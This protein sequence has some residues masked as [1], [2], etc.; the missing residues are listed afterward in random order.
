VTGPGARAA[1]GAGRH[2]AGALRLALAAEQTAVYGYGVLGAH[3]AGQAQRS[4]TADW[5]AHQV[6]RDR[7][8]ALLRSLGVVPAAAAVAYR[9][10]APVRTPAEARSL[11][12]LLEERVAAAY[13]S[14]VALS[15]RRLRALGAE[16]VR[17]S[18]LRAASWR[19]ATVAF[20]GLPGRAGQPPAA[21]SPGPRAP[22]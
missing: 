6:A 20:P 10:P 19:G 3:L 4:A 13:L 18:A 17:Q 5:I 15:D 12:V 11:A 9:L 1:G 16:R 14:V 22:G 7:L 8:E 21:V 2:A